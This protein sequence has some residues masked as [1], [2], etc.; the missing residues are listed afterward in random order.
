MP[1]LRWVANVKGSSWLVVYVLSDYYFVWR[2]FLSCSQKERRPYHQH[3]HLHTQFLTASFS[4]SSSFCYLLVCKGETLAE[5][6]KDSGN[7]DDIKS[8]NFDINTGK[9]TLVY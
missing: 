3:H 5:E 7:F 6:K 8:R 2:D 4:S 9:L 1:T